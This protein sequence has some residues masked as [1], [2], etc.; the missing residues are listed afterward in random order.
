MLKFMGE[1]AMNGEKDMG[2]NMKY[3]DNKQIR[4]VIKDE[5]RSQ[6]KSLADIARALGMMP[7]TLNS[8]FDKKHIAFDDVMRM[9]DVLGCDLYFGL[10]KRQ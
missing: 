7:Q 9:A 2:D 1:C 5:C 10:V 3:T 4:D 6:G 8:V